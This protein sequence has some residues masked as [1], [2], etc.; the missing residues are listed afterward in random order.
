MRKLILIA[1]LA[2]S[3]ILAQTG[4]APCSHSAAATV[5]THPAITR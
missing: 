5:A 4:A 1:L 3:T 2:A